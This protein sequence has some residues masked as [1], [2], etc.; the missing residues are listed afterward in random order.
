MKN[1]Q[2]L[3][4]KYN[5]D[6][7]T[8][9]FA[10]VDKE[11]TDITIGTSDKFDDLVFQD[12]EY[13][14]VLTCL[15]KLVPIKDFAADIS[16]IARYRTTEEDDVDRV[17]NFKIYDGS[18]VNMNGFVSGID[19]E[20][21]AVLYEN[22]N[23]PPDTFE[24]TLQNPKIYEKRFQTQQNSR[25]IEV[26]EEQEFEETDVLHFK[27]GA[28]FFA[29]SYNKGINISEIQPYLFYV[30]TGFQTSEYIEIISARDL[31]NT[32]K[33]KLANGIKL[34]QLSTLEDDVSNGEIKISLTNI[35]YKSIAIK[36]NTLIS[37]VCKII[38]R[39]G[40]VK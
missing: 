10:Y 30:G 16:I 5:N 37:D 18:S 9:G 6:P 8:N 38:F 23:A 17:M 1:T 4:L 2:K 11:N 14:E 29:G 27:S 24:Q 19:I 31:L 32:N 3:K 20:L 39:K 13:P 7:F 40:D 22:N 26:L 12:D 36:K 33:V 35:V 28:H 21:V 15:C 25:E 34:S